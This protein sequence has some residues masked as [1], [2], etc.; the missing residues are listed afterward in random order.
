[1]RHDITRNNVVSLRNPAEQADLIAMGRVISWRL[2]SLD[3]EE[4][5]LNEM[6]DFED[7]RYDALHDRIL[8]GEED[9]ETLIELC[10]IVVRL[11]ELMGGGYD[12]PRLLRIALDNFNMPARQ[13]AYSESLLN[14][15]LEDRN[16]P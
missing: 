13:V 2:A 6:L 15:L 7:P 9:R 16:R 4:A 10:R 12:N 14:G 11:S 8:K 1:M 3:R 5:A